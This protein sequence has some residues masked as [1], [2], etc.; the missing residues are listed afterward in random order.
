[1][2]VLRVLCLHR[3]VSTT[4]VHYILCIGRL[5]L[6]DLDCQLALWFVYNRAL[7]MSVRNGRLES[8]LCITPIVDEMLSDANLSEVD[9]RVVKE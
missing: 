1:M 7:L 8:N 6:A 5:C 2:Y 9:C 4:N 3:F